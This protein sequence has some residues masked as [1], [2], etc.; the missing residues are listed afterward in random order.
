MGRSL[1]LRTRRNLELDVRFYDRR[2][3][4]AFGLNHFNIQ[5]T[6]GKPDTLPP[7][8]SNR[9]TY[10]Y[11]RYIKARKAFIREGDELIVDKAIKPHGNVYLHGYWQSE[12]LFEASIEHI[13]S[14]LSPAR[15]PTKQQSEVLLRVG[16]CESVAIHVRRGDYISNPKAKKLYA[17]CPNQYYKN[18]IKM[19]EEKVINT[20]KPFVFSDDP[21][22]VADNLNLGT[23][24]EIMSTGPTSLPSH[25]LWTMAN[26]KHQVIANST[27]SW[28][29]AWLNRNPEKVVVAP[30]QW[31]RNRTSL[32]LGLIPDGWFVADNCG[33]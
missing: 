24:M 29:A 9:L 30:R 15:P 13:R 27:F 25:E 1:S 22:W 5:A 2:N 28:W 26:C 3:A 11:W 33:A 21:Q 4:F 32:D 8:K 16:S 31:T 10:L 17:D 18:A 19:I 6:I 23:R 20:V 14:D 7:V 12:R